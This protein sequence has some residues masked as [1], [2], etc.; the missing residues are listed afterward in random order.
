MGK[1]GEER[2]VTL[3]LEPAQDQWAELFKA[4]VHKL[5]SNLS[6]ICPKGVATV[7]ME[8]NISIIYLYMMYIAIVY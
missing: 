5:Q 1:E 6:S 7:V 2:T 3:Y 8:N 4:T